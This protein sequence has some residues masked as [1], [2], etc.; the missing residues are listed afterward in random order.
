VGTPE[1]KKAPF[2]AFFN[3]VLTWGRTPWFDRMPAAAGGEAGFIN[4]G[5][6]YRGGLGLQSQWGRQLI[7][8]LKESNQRKKDG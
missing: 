6:P 7:S 3:F 1:L 5:I 4:E 8:F 2:V